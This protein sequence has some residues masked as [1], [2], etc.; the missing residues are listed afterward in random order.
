MSCYKPLYAMQLQNNKPTI[1]KRRPSEAWVKQEE[2]YGYRYL[3]LPCG[4]CIGCT[5][6]RSRDWAIRCVL[7]T[8]EHE[9]NQFITL[10][11][12]NEHLPRF[13]LNADHLQ[14]FIKKL[15]RHYEYHYQH[16]G[17][18]F[19]AC[20]EYGEKRERPHFH[21]IAFNLPLKDKEHVLTTK[22]GDKLYMSETLTKIWGKGRVIVGEVNWYTSAYVARYITKRTNC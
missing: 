3:Q 9:E 12:A 7:E 19:L 15:R 21:I 1:L 6:D 22:N 20:G 11:Y 4:K 10:T 18:R 17:I 13:G 8:E 14:A 16:K 2:S 5:L